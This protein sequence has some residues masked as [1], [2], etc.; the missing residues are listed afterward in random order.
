M[1]IKDNIVGGACDT[2][3]AMGRACVRRSEVMGCRDE[4]VQGFNYL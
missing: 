1:S 4:V 2:V 3:I